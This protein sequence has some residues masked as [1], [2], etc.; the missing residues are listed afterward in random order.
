MNVWSINLSEE[1]ETHASEP[2]M[3]A[4]LLKIAEEFKAPV[5]LALIMALTVTVVWLATDHVSKDDFQRLNDK[6]SGVQYTLSHD[7]IDTRI[8]TVRTDIFNLTQ[9][10]KEETTKGYVDR[11]SEERLNE[12]NGEEEDLKNQLSVLEHQKSF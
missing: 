1:P 5:S 8:H 9:H 7:H 2:R 11:T 4:I 10:I 3:I 6:L 12:L